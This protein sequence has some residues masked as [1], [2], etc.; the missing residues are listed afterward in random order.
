MCRKIMK[1]KKSRKYQLSEFIYLYFHSY[2][3]YINVYIYF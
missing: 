2:K 3:R 1:Q